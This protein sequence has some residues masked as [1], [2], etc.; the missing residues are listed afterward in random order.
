[1]LCDVAY[2]RGGVE[3]N[4]KRKYLLPVKTPF[5]LGWDYSVLGR[6]RNLLKMSVTNKVDKRIVFE[7]CTLA[8]SGLK[9]DTIYET[10]RGTMLPTNGT[11]TKVKI[12]IYYG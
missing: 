4:F 1:M 7:E 11:H 5:E 10:Q 8:G 6:G 2:Q 3:L 9:I 12:P